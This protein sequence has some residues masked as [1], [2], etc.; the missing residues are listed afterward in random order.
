MVPS[1]HQNPPQNEA[2]DDTPQNQN[3]AGQPIDAPSVTPQKGR[4]GIM[5]V[6]N[7]FARPLL[8]ASTVMIV[9]GAIGVAQRVGWIEN[10]Q[11][12]PTGTTTKAAASPDYICPMMCTPPQ[13][14]P[15]RCPVCA[16]ELV[17]ASSESNGGDE[18]S[19]VID[20][21]SR[22][23]ANIQTVEARAHAADQIIHAVGEIHYDESRLKTI[24]AY[25]DGRF[26][27]LHIDFTGAV[28][29]QGEPLATFYS[30][31][32]Y[33][34]QVEYLQASK[35]V[36]QLSGQALASVAES[37][38]R[39]RD[40]ARQRLIELGMTEDQIKS[41]IENRAARSRMEIVA[42]MSG[43]VIEKLAVEGEYVKE[44]EPIFKLAD[45]TTV[46]LMLELFPAEA[47]LLEN[48]QAVAAKLKSLPNQVFPGEITFISPEVDP[49]SRTVSVRVAMNNQ[50]GKLRIGDYAKATIRVPQS[51]S[52]SIVIPRNAVLM[53]A[54]HCVVY[55]E[56]E[57]GRFEI[58]RIETGSVC[59]DD[60]IVTKGL[61]VG[62]LVA[63]KGNFLL[64][65]QM[66][67]VGNPSL[68]DPTRAA[69]PREPY[70]GFTPE[71]L[72]EIDQL[73]AVDQKLALDQ[74]ICPVTDFKLGSMGV[75]PKVMVDGKPVFLCCEGCR[76]SL[77]ENSEAHLK[78]IQE[79][80]PEAE[81]KQPQALEEGDT[82][83]P[84]G[85]M[86]LTEDD[87]SLPPLGDMQLITPEKP[88]TTDVQSE[89]GRILR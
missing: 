33:S 67:L 86:S 31:D 77:M 13:K 35:S 30:P 58:R 46:W 10:T 36:T 27:H 12:D 15:G 57:P 16:M 9:L 40:N 49:Q 50:K 47:A 7:Y 60:V 22:R 66:Q 80:Q 3:P 43:T 56:T 5:S 38:R 34:A 29:T 85:E 89:S 75:P 63:T 87:D 14:E 83:P 1:S 11:S 45:L 55:V 17:P 88:R 76:E 72:A 21:A 64:D 61:S 25:T 71:M 84:L 65:S 42:P 4:G 41:L 18:R 23:V 24:S 32:L 2:P 81:G 51:D 79:Y 28:V 70:P 20:P 68:I 48:G 19:I 73:S 37:N 44:G 8:F 69:A 39:L 52:D 59:E 6:L 53:A 26:D 62:E 74:V 54:D 82:L 78:K